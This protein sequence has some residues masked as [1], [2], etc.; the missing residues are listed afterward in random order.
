MTEM[1]NR[2]LLL[3]G[4]PK[5]AKS[6]S[7]SLGAY[8]LGK[9]ESIGFKTQKIHIQTSMHSPEG[10]QSMLELVKASDLLILAFPL[11]IDCLPAA[12]ISALEDIAQQRK[13]ADTPKKQRFLAIVNNGFPE[14]SQNNTALAICRRFAFKAGFEWAGGLSLGGGGPIEGKPLEQ[15]GFIARNVRKSLDLA[16]ADLL[17]NQPVSQA[18]VDL[19]A[20]PIVPK[21]LYLLM[22]NRGWKMMAKRF[23]AEDK[24]Y[25]KPLDD[26][27]QN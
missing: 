14:A 25:S 21:G 20:K 11:Y 27:K 23:S 7:E 15:V 9:L 1:P 18:I 6:Y 5:P 16:A 8:L 24:L 26:C 4:S 2:A 19:M 3:I 12:V 17:Q 10:K 13:N 22:S